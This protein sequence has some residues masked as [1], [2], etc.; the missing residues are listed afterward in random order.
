MYSQAVLPAPLP[1]VYYRKFR[2]P[3]QEGRADFFID[4]F[5]IAEQTLPH[6]HNDKKAPFVTFF[7]KMQIRACG[8]VCPKPCTKGFS[9]KFLQGARGCISLLRCGNL[10]PQVCPLFRISAP[11]GTRLKLTIQVV[12]IVQVVYG[13]LILVVIL[14]EAVQKLKGFGKIFLEADELAL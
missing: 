8:Q 4:T 5:S 12:Q 7:P 14:F 13:L 1:M 6:Y 2:P 10:H 9:V 3:C 11:P